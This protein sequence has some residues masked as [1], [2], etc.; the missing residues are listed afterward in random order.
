MLFEEYRIVCLNSQGR[1]R[2]TLRLRG[3]HSALALGL[4]VLLLGATAAYLPLTL[5][6]VRERLALDSARQAIMDQKKR[7]YAASFQLK[8]M[9]DAFAGI[10]EFDSKLRVML[11]LDPGPTQDIP[12][13]GNPLPGP[14]RNPLQLLYTQSLLRDMRERLGDLEVSMLLEEAS[15]QDL[16]RAVSVQQERLARIPV[17]WPTRGRFTSRFGWRASPL[18]GKGRF[19]KGIDVTAPTGT[20]IKATAQG[21]VVMAEWFSTYGQCVE[22]D[23]GGGIH[24]RYGHMSKILV[25]E[26]QTVFRG[27]VIGLVGSTG[28]SV[29]PHVHYEVHVG[30]TPTNPLNYILR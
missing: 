21:R 19:H 18:T 23:H 22:I 20:P 11:S 24:T 12:G 26:G 9:E 14:Y 28:R 1:P 6:M 10:A 27:D 15:Q 13:M 16:F 4:L 25:K 8:S 5:N 2:L 17:I 30:G 29:A 3:W 7:I